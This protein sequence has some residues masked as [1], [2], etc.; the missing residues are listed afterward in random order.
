[1]ACGVG[2]ITLAS[3]AAVFLCGFLLL[4]NRMGQDSPRH[5]ELE[6]ESQTRAFPSSSVEKIL[7]AS[8]ATFELHEMT[9]DD[10]ARVKYLVNVRSDTDLKLLSNNLMTL[11]NEGLHSVTWSE[12]KWMR[13]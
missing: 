2:A 13:Q 5:L 11:G 1:M 6:V 12:K 9:M 8:G 4:L 7:A 3:L 10:R